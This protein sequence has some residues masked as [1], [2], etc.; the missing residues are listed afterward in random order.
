MYK[1]T[2]FGDNWL[3]VIPQFKSLGIQYTTVVDS[4]LYVVVDP[5]IFTSK[6]KGL[7]WDTLLIGKNRSINSI[8]V[9]D[10]LIFAATYS[11]VFRCSINGSNWTQISTGLV[12][13]FVYSI[14]ATGTRVFAGTS[15]GLFYSSNNGDNW[16]DISTGLT[17]KSILRLALSDNKVLAGTNNSGIWKL[18]LS[19]LAVTDGNTPTFPISFCYPNPA[20]TTL[21]ID[22]SSLPFHTSTPVTCT[23]TSLTGEVLRQF[24]LQ[25]TRTTLPLDDFASGVYM[26]TLRQGLQRSSTLFS[27]FH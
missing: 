21:T 19:F 25:E 27:I 6:D 18:D 23:I 16:I 5:G 26:I 11:G 7:H 1:S 12:S 2:D 20:T 24:E 15:N 9:T 14:V 4:T 13:T 10:S 17:D 3:R 22:Y 8:A